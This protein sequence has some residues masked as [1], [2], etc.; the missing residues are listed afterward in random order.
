MSIEKKLTT[1]RSEM[2]KNKI[3]I[4][5]VPSIDAHNNEY[6][7][8]CFERR[9]WISGFTGSAGEALV[10]MEHAYL[11]TDG[12]YFLQ[13][14]QELNPDY[15]SLMR[16]N[17]FV[18]EIEAWILANAEDKTLGV[19]PRVVSI[20]RANHLQ[21]VMAKVNGK[22]VFLEDNLIDNSKHVLQEAFNFPATDILKHEEKYSGKSITEKLVY[23]SHELIKLDADYLVL[24]VLDEI[25]WVFNIR[26]SDIKF[27]PLVMSYAIIGKEK[28]WLFLNTDKV[29]TNLK[30]ELQKLN[31]IL[32]SY[33][34][35]ARQL[36][37]LNGR[38]VFDPKTANYWML[39]KL[40]SAATIVH[41]KSPVV[42]AKACKNNIEQ[43]G[44]KFAH[45][46]D[47]KAVIGFFT[48]LNRNWQN[49]VDELSAE[50]KLHEFR[51]QQENFK[52][53]SFA[54]IS[55]FA[56]NGAIIHYR[57]SP[58]TNKV[59]D[60]SNLYLLDSGG[61]Y[62]EGTTDITRTIHLGVPTS[63]QKRHY[64]LVL[65]GHLALARAKFPQGT[66]GEHLDTL[67]RQYLW[68]DYLD[69]R[70]GT[71]HGVGSFL[72]VHE[73]P[74]KIS[75]AISATPLLAGM[76]VSNEPGF[77]LSGHYGIRIENLCLVR[78]CSGKGATSEFGPFFEFENL[79]LVPYCKKLLDFSLLDEREIKQI[80]D[81]YNSIKTQVRDLLS[82]EEQSWFDVE[83]NI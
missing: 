64:T 21:S 35:I 18:P 56:G 29:D 24:N 41:A 16:Q 70:H 46:K 32:C 27:N 75:K 55:G 73:G 47:A 49:G 74:Q 68:A 53:E 67:A 17:G 20:D 77:Y 5:L 31:I 63:E 3:D 61:Q 72:C 15:Y 60:D 66:C 37:M 82:I 4:Y 13:A 62:I 22:V 65:K 42:I 34:D 48:W 44:S 57:S 39:N 23:I 28:S 8:Q 11:W 54:T 9:Q 6:L 52:Q 19:D 43:N 58:S 83:I 59:I 1:L 71:G 30:I 81:Y 7:P 12:R 25:A 76:I 45:I 10:T 38:V 78:A 14:E 80:K 50:Q 69:Y 26:G 51:L 33:A 2:Q 36:S 40:N 79:T